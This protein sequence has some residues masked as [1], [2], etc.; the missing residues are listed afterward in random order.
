MGKKDKKSKNADYWDDEFAEDMPEPVE[1]GAVAEPVADVVTETEVETEV[2]PAKP[3]PA[4]EPETPAV[5]VLKS[6]KE[7]E[8]ERKEREKQKKKE[9]AA[10]RKAAAEAA[11][12]TAAS[13]EASEPEPTPEP[14][15]EPVDQVTEELEQTSIQEED[16]PKKT[17]AKKK[18]AGAVAALKKQMEAKR[19]AEEEQARLEEEQR[20]REEEERLRLEEE[21][22]Q[23]QLAREAKKEKERLKKEELRAQGKLLTKKEK[24]AAAA[25][26]R[27]LQ[28]LLASGV[29]ISGLNEGEKKVKPVYGKK[30]KPS[31]KPAAAEPAAEP[32]AAAVAAVPAPSE[33]KSSKKV[34]APPEL[35]AAKEEPK[36]NGAAPADDDDIADSWE[37]ALDDEETKDEEDV[38]ASWEEMANDEPEESWEAMA[39]EETTESKTE[40]KEE[41]KEEPIVDTKTAPKPVPKAEPKTEKKTINN[42]EDAVSKIPEAEEELET[43]AEKPGEDLRSPICCILGHVDTGKTKVLDK[44]R[45]TNVQEGEAGGITQQIGATYF[46]VDAIKQKTAVMKI[47]DFEYKIPGLLIIDTPGHESFTNLR[48]RGSSLCNIAIL[49]IDIMHGLEQQTIES[50]NLLKARKTPFIVALNKIDRLYG[51]KPIPNN[52]V[53]NSLNRQ[54]KSVQ[55]EFQDRM[56]N[57]K[58]QLAEQELNSEVYYLNKKKGSYVSLVPTSAVTGE[59]IPDLLQLLVELTQ[60]RMAS[61]LMYLS[62]LECTV[63]EV[64]VIEGLGTTIDV[65]LS[66]GILHEGDRIVVCGMNGGI[67]TNVRALLTPQPLRELRIKS[68]YVHHKQVKA[69]LGVKIA[70][71]DLDKAIAGSRLLVVGPDDNEEEVLR[72]VEKDFQDLKKTV[73]SSGKG[74]WVQA[75]TLGSLEALL[76]FLRSMKIPVMDFSIGPVF[77]KDVMMAA[78][79]LERA[80]QFAVM[81]CFDVK[82]DKEAEAYAREQ[83][84]K[85]F[86]AD[87]IYHLFDKF[88][89]YQ[90]ELLDQKRKENASKLVYPCILKTLQI[91][92]KR[93]P[94]IIGVDLVEGTLRV[95]TPLAIV[96]NDNEGH[97]QVLRLGRVVSMEV[98]H[99][100]VETVKKGQ[101]GAGVAVRLDADSGAPTW[102]RHI[103]ES[104]PIYSAI[105]QE[106]VNLLKDKAFRDTVTKADW[107]LMKRLSKEVGKF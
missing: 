35:V 7:K 57:I 49:V 47:K 106:S 81:L 73:S 101:S 58:V 103:D 61:R 12:A 26:E 95:G 82:V 40:P 9:E 71:N 74:V 24:E 104:D 66:N 8:R 29:Q 93:N 10:K 13:I 32:A 90:E 27:K 70:A 1:F 85:L 3:T 62:K 68:E 59:G 28:A 41:S 84:V 36:S 31:V 18:H 100:A 5:P 45:Q 77:K 78:T 80:P 46:P 16:Q 96:K 75:S 76:D 105:T 51:W 4:K 48:S 30:K 98:N 55:R 72:E 87:I 53:R 60:T 97:R 20:R 65:V 19:K 23:A 69:A 92:N 34:A 37:A 64:K 56:E 86:K 50:I 2:E 6:K 42:T 38:G 44:I 25:R 63:L 21:E 83:G 54:S 88:K 39:D 11:A 14:E 107:E 43:S 89:A 17:K 94:M 79:M 22:R 67:A 99:K 52:A 91:I 102:G 15:P 33:V